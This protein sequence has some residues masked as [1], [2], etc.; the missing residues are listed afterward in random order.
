L[1]VNRELRVIVGIIGSLALRFLHLLNPYWDDLLQ[2][3]PCEVTEQSVLAVL[4]SLLEAITKSFAKIREFRLIGKGTQ[5]SHDL[6]P[7]MKIGV[8]DDIPEVLANN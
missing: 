3:G 2:L 8:V 4:A 6:R 5:C 7:I 1:N